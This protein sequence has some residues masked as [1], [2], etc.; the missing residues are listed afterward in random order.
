MTSLLAFAIDDH[1]FA[2]P[3]ERVERAIRAVAIT[4]L[5]QSPAIV[6]GVID[7]AGF[8]MPVIDLRRRCG[9]P[10]RPLGLADQLL[11]ARSS[12]RQLAM[13]VDAALGVIDCAAQDFV[14]VDSIV[15]GT[16]Y[17][18]G[19]VKG[20]S[21]MILIHDL[22]TFL[23]LEESAVLDLALASIAEAP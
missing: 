18:R 11:I 7:I 14:A 2:L 23:S 9:L 19:I 16:N 21:G 20:P 6:L 15:P 4:P 3:L 17:L 5:P 13:V 22:D 8:I 10:E 12:Q 1:T